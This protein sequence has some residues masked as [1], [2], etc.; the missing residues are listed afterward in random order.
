METHLVRARLNETSARGGRIASTC[1]A[2]AEGVRS[3]GNED[4]RSNQRRYDVGMDLVTTPRIDLH[5]DAH[6]RIAFPEKRPI[7]RSRGFEVYVMD[8][9]PALGL[10]G[11]PLG[12]RQVLGNE[13][14]DR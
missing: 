12:S 2:R 6:Q 9:Q 1:L 7:L 8:E 13:T 11:R 3:S 5:T 4:R 10:T 14:H